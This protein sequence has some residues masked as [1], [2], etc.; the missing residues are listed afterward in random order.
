MN[1]TAASLSFLFSLMTAA[2]SAYALQPMSVEPGA[3]EPAAG[4]LAVGEPAPE[5][6]LTDVNGKAHSLSGYMGKHVVLEWTN[7]DC[8]FVKKHYG[9]GN[10]Q[11]LQKEFSTRGVVWLSINSSAVGKQ[12][13]YPPEQWRRILDEKGSNADATLL[14]PLGTV[15]R[16]Y[17]AKTTPHMFVINPEGTLIYA[18]AIDD[19][20]SADPADIANSTNYVR[21]ALNE[22]LAGKKSITYPT[23]KPYGCGVK[24]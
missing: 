21:M 10:M 14:D 8:P 19:I 22:S 24:Y 9:G 1:R 11:A 13:N 7:P 18:G 16:L 20:A 4:E 15:G 5:F 17:G 3:D 6:T 12:G 2:H 23:S